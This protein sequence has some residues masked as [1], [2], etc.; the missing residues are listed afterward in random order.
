MQLGVDIGAWADPCLIV[1]LRLDMLLF[2]LIIVVFLH[3]HLHL[4]HL[5]VVEAVCLFSFLDLIQ[6]LLDR[7]SDLASGTDLI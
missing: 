7:A 3:V 2:L 4:Q 5:V 1:F 6:V